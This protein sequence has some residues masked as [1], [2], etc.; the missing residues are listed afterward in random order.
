VSARYAQHFLVNRHA[1]ERI[2]ASVAAGPGDAVLEIGPGKGAITGLLLA[3]SRV[4]VVEIDE[5]WAQL[6]RQRHAG[7]NPH[8]EVINADFLEFDLNRL[9]H[10]RP[11]KVVGN[12]PYNLT[13]PI[14]RKL[15]EWSGWSEATVMVQKEVGDRLCA[16]VGTAAYGALT[17]GMNLTCTAERV[18]DLSAKSFDP[19]PKVASTVV[20]LRRRP[21][22]LFDD[23]DRVQRVIQAAFQQRRKT[24]ENSFS[25]GL[26]LEKD[27]VRVALQGL[28]LDPAL[29]AERLST[30]DFIRVT[31]R[32]LPAC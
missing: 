26:H 5:K 24:I 13:S 2:G 10:D 1:A 3:A 27:A 25:H 31:R 32:L 18:F 12:L 14:L 9:V 7:K 19:P 17:A 4:V 21:T 6:L 29:R 30:E 20:R 22:P 8:L 11:F 15:S 16:A 28:G 23:I